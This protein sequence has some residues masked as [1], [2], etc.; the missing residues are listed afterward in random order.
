MKVTSMLQ[1]V[2][3]LLACLGQ[4][5][6]AQAIPTITTQWGGFGGADFGNGG[7]GYVN[8][9]V[10][11]N[12]DNPGLPKK[13]VTVGLGGDKFVTSNTSYEFSSNGWFNTWCVDITHWMIPGQ[14]TYAVGSTADMAQD[15]S[16]QRV[17]DLLRLAN[18]DYALVK[19]QTSSAA[20]QQAI[21]AIVTG[22]PSKGKYTLNSATYVAPSTN[23][24]AALAQ[25]WLNNLDSA[26]V[27]GN[28]DLTYLYQP[29]GVPG[30]IDNT[31]DMVVFTAP[32][33]E[34][35]TFFLLAI[36]IV[37]VFSHRW[38]RRNKNKPSI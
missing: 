26:P 29:N 4:P 31:Q 23:P 15:F 28:Y 38:S 8:G 17:T 11:P 33:P 1:T 7:V 25:L 12:P 34:P 37:V 10:W 5:Q 30:I 3:L 19:D 13:Q 27:T 35:T 20:F 18:E 6:L 24:G 2:A 14:V 22:T 9:S 32:V 21:W 16:Q 36:G